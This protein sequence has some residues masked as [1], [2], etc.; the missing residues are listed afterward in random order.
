MCRAVV[1]SAVAVVVCNV[2]IVMVVVSA[3]ADMMAIAAVVT[4]AL[5]QVETTRRRVG[6]GGCLEEREKED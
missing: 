6:V 4:M 5:A 3:L 2:V 1:A